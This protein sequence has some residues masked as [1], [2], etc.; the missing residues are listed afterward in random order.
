MNII[1]SILMVAEV[2][3]ALLL[4]AIILMQRS[5]SGG[6]L[7]ALAGGQTEEVFGSSASS[8]LTKTTIALSII[9][10]IL[11]LS[12]AVLQGNALKDKN[13]SVV[14]SVLA[15]TEFVDE[16]E[17]QEPEEKLTGTNEVDVAPVSD[18]VQPPSAPDAGN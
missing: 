13:T 8:I 12:L 2:I 7:G 9:F 6:G 18:D 4:I 14:D 3:T 1:L 10:F 11:T 15:D 5:K 17:L 16:P